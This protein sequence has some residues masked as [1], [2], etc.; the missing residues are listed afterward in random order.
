M[1]KKCELYKDCKSLKYISTQPNLS[2]RPRRWLEL[3]EDYK[4]SINHH[5]YGSK[6][7][8]QRSESKVPCELIGSREAAV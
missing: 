7:G 8:S 6:C 2:L 1:K 5:P 3:I 4:P